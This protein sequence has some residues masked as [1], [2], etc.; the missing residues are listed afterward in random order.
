[1]QGDALTAESGADAADAD[2]ALD[3]A[4]AAALARRTS[5]RADLRQS[6]GWIAFGIVVI[7]LSWRMDR[8]ER[9]DINPYTV[10]GLLPGCLGIAVVLF[11]VLMLARSWRRMAHTEPVSAE[12]AR[13]F[14]AIERTNEKSALER[15]E[16]KRIWTVL[17]LCIGYAA[18]LMGH[19]LPFWLA[20][21]LFVAVAIGV[22]QFSER[23]I[24][25]QRARGAIFALGMGVAT[26]LVTTFVFQDLFLVRL[27]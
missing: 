26:G 23:T 22:L 18:G 10:P 3:E 8:L 5:P 21:S 15:T 6:L 16:A 24:L 11:G 4:E 7:V 19:G 9:Q 1:M 12:P 27:P 13:G 20:T 14:S 2:A 17:T 25:H